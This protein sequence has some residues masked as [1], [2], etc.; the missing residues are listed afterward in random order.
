MSMYNALFG[1]NPFA[2]VL[3]AVLDIDQPEGKYESGRFRDI[4]LSNDGLEITLY[5]RN[6]GGN[7]EAYQHIFDRLSEHPL[8][9]ED[10]DDDYDCTYAYITFKT[11]KDFL[12][13][14]KMM[15]DTQDNRSIGDK[16]QRLC[17]DLK[18]GKRSGTTERAL[19]VGNEIIGKINASLE[20][21]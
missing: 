18:E 19:K 6:G 14:A 4:Y 16:F 1:M 8:F 2:K 21:Q 12:P 9:I 3:L 10:H 17:S 13:Q 11:P 5:T 15:I 7:R 20:K